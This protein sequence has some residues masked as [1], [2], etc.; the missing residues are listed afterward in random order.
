MKTITAYLVTTFLVFTSCNFSKNKKDDAQKEMEPQNQ[1][2]YQ[3]NSRNALDWSDTYRGILPCADCEGIATEI[4]LNQDLSYSKKV[5]YIGKSD[6]IIKSDGTFSW[7]ETGNNIV[8]NGVDGEHYKVGEIA[9][10]VLDQDGK[11]K[12]SSLSEHYKLVKASMDTGIVGKYWRLIELEGQ[13]VE[14]DPNL[15]KEIHLVLQ[16]NDSI[17]SGF[18]GCNGFSGPYEFDDEEQRLSFSRI[19]STLMACEALQ[20]E[21]MFHK[22]LEKTDNYSVKGDTLSLKNGSLEPLAKLVAEYLH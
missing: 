11:L 20:T 19:R 21:D 22:A 1:R 18:G 9:L 10:M 15:K 2:I 8:L 12:T 4:T 16:Q 5:R 13:K 7:D 6:E 17:V 3:D 14:V